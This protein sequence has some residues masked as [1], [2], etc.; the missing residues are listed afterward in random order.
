MFP[1]KAVQAKLEQLKDLTAAQRRLRN[2]L[3]TEIKARSILT[4]PRLRRA[5]DGF[6]PRRDARARSD[7][8]H[9]ATRARVRCSRMSSRR[10]TGLRSS[11]RACS[12]SATG[13][14]PTRARYSS[15]SRR[16]RRA[17]CAT[18]SLLN[19]VA[20]R[21]VRLL[22]GV[23]P[24]ALAPPGA[25]RSALLAGARAVVRDGNAADVPADARRERRRPPLQYRRRADRRRA[26]RRVRP[27]R[28][29]RQAALVGARSRLF[30]GGRLGDIGLALLVLWLAAQVNP[31][32]PLFAVTFDPELRA[33]PR[34]AV[35]TTAAT[36]PRS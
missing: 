30:L 10:C 32:I 35:A 21:A 5:A 1:P 27:A 15:C 12:R 28:R 13:W 24:A 22:R 7:G 25:T 3:W 26:R 23:A 11:T 16:G 6:R 34:R 2:K 18:T 31:G 4:A 20:L 14:R 8:A 36:A 29:R 9:R 33:H 19:V 17:G